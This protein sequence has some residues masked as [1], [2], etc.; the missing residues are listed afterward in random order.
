MYRFRR[1]LAIVV[2]L[3][4][5]AHAQSGKR[6]RPLGDGEIVAQEV[7]LSGTTTLNSSQLTDIGNAL[8]SVTMHDSDDEVAERIKY[9]FQQRG[10]FD[11]EVTNL[12]V[13]ELDPLAKKKP[14]RVEAEV[15]EGPQF[16]LAEF[17]FRGTRPLPPTNF[18][19]CFRYI[20]VTCSTPRR[21]GLA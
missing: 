2:I 14:V 7:V 5:G 16:R 20:R 19:R 3:V 8:S 9:E 1:V 18:V 13:V 12:K 15:S 4:L 10:Y 21:C 6:K 11:A 17:R